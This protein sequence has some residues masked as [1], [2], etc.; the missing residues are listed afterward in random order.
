MESSRKHAIVVLFDTNFLMIAARFHFDLFRRV[1]D[2]LDSRFQARILSPNF[3]ELETLAN[4]GRPSVQKQAKAA[5]QIAQLCETIDFKSSGRGADN[6]IVS[7][8]SRSPGTVV[9]TNDRALRSKLRRARTTVLS[10]RREGG[11]ELLGNGT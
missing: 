7:Y 2:T 10:L 9:A 3:K 4:H 11:L 6:D 1:E 5:L 8:T